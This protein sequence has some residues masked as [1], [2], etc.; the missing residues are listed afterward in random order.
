MA[1]APDAAS[2]QGWI[3]AGVTA[4]AGTV[5]QVVGGGG[6]VLVTFVTPKAMANIVVSAASITTG[7]QYAIYTGGTASG[8]SIG[9]L[10]E[11]GELGSA[12]QAATVTA[13]QAPAGG[14]GGGPGGGRRP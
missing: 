7:E 13:G 8:A 5:V 4:P 10:A 9:G 12:T 6:E 3:A 11:S 2:K 1:V 14:M